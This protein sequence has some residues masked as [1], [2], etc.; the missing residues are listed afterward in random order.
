MKEEPNA[1][2]ELGG[3][4]DPEAIAKQKAEW[5]EKAR[6]RDYLTHR[7]FA[8]TESGRELLEIY[9]RELMTVATVK[10]NMD[11]LEIGLRAGMKEFARQIVMIVERVEKG[12]R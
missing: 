1:F 11:L 10:P 8:E 5:E 4:A 6:R 7:V 12:E 2:D 9:K 3:E